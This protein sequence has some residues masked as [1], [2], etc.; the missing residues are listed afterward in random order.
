MSWV[1]AA[2]AII[3][4]IASSNAAGQMASA[5]QD[6]ASLQAQSA[7]AT[8]AQQQSMF[9]TTQ[10]NMQPFMQSGQGALSQLVSGTQN[11]SFNPQNLQLQSYGA[12]PTLQGYGAAPTLQQY[13]P[14]TATSYANSPE[15][16][17]AANNQA[18][19]MGAAQ[20]GA[21]LT[22]GMNSNNLNSLMA[23]TQANSI[24][25][26]STGLADY[27]NQ[28]N[29]GNTALTNQYNLN[30]TATGLNNANATNQFGLNNQ[31][32]GL[33]NSNATAEN[34]SYNQNLQQQFANLQTMAGSSQN[35]AAGLGAMSANASNAMANTQIGASQA[36]AQGIIGSATAQA[37]GTMGIANAASNGV[38]QLVN[39]NTNNS[40]YN[41]Y[42][43]QQYGGTT[44]SNAAVDQLYTAGGYNPNSVGTYDMTSTYSDP[45]AK[46]NIKKTGK[47]VHDLILYEFN[48]IWDKSKRYIG[49]MSNEVEKI[50]PEAVIKGDGFDRVNYGMLG[51]EM[52][53]V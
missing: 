52:V 43:Q 1:G 29:A 48:Y 49:V 30:N 15:A 18:A 5:N 9:N 35:A 23:S 40:A 12:A 6:A 13:T 21:S 26:Y 28:F 25:G 38:N 27:Q 24:N 32:I 10:A 46:E 31:T 22:G 34:S 41:Q 3:G 16:Q 11:G 37:A 45:R 42:L 50:M 17:I 8:L 7:A 4:G 53:E 20:N 2:V 33:N 44:G 14:Y 47:T 39:Y 51:I 36:A 19:M